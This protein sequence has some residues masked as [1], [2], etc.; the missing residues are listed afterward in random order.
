MIVVGGGVIGLACAWR[1]A[2]SA[3]CDVLVLERGRPE[4]APPASRRGCWRRSARRA[5]ARRRC[6]RSRSIRA[7]AGPASP[8]SS[9]RRAG[10]T[11]GYRALRRAARRP[12]RDEAAEL[13]RRHRA[14]CGE[15]GL[16]AEWLTPRRCRELEPGLAPASPAASHAPGEAAVDPR[17]LIAA[18]LAA[19]DR[20]RAAR[21]RG[22]R[23][24]EALIEGGAARSGV[25]IA[26]G[27]ELPRRRASCSPPAPG[28]ARRA[29]CPSGRARRCARSRAR[30]SRLR[31]PAAEPVCERIVAGERVYIV[32][33]ADG[34]LVV[35]ATV[36]ERGFDTAGHRRRRPRAA[37]RGL[38]GAARDRRA[39]AGRGGRRA[40][41][42][43]A[44][45]RCR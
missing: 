31:G 32:P 13:R 5:G 22:Q 6:W 37:A 41:P 21:S 43:D 8:P 26:R 42:G 44:R 27:E 4:P 28:R 12:R 16:E 40:A 35:G 45:Q 24:S 10:S 1:A 2:R 17:A 14:P 3:A 15:L 29:G 38:P 7:G 20:A 18:L 19:L 23:G 25:R 11:S 9:R 34:R 33:R 30:S 39:R 36:E